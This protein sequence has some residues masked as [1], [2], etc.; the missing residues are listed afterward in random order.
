[1][2]VAGHSSWRSPRSITRLRRVSDSI[3]TNVQIPSIAGTLVLPIP[4]RRAPS[5]LHTSHA[6]GRR[7][8]LIE[9][10]R[11]N[12]GVGETC[13]ESRSENRGANTDVD[14]AFVIGDRISLGRIDPYALG[15]R[16]QWAMSGRRC[17]ARVTH[18]NVIL[19][20]V[21]RTHRAE[22]S[23]VGCMPRSCRGVRPAWYTLTGLVRCH[24]ARWF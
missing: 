4:G 15:V 23:A 7:G 19:G 11:D 13:G 20:L 9:L 2:E 1:M 21:P 3:R 12:E 24:A 8:G 22:H 18:A 6:A 5:G 10:Y 16:Q 17:A 14:H